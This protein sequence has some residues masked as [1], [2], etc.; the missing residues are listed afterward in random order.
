MSNPVSKVLVGTGVA[1]K[2]IN[3]LTEGQLCGF[4]Y[5]APG[6]I[7]SDSVRIGFAMGT[8][9]PGQPVL[10]AIIPAGSITDALRNN[11]QAPRNKEM[12]LTVTDV[13]EAGKSAVFKINYQDSLSIVPNQLK[14]TMVSIQA[15]DGETAASFATKIAAAFNIQEDNLFCT[16]TASSNVVT[17]AANTVSTQ[18]KYNRINRPES[19]IFTISVPGV[20][21]AV[22]T[23]S[24]ATT[25]SH[26]AGQ[27]DPAKVAYMED[28]AQGRRGYSDRRNVMDPKRFSPSVNPSSTYDVVVINATVQVHDFIGSTQGAPIGVVLAVDTNT[29]TGAGNFFEEMAEAVTLTSVPA[30]S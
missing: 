22:G 21:E 7:T 4:D 19:L 28:Q 9:T 18:S 5:D 15:V 12:E 30:S 3:T 14:N 2:D 16:V 13:P 24:T 29:V 23:Y 20:D 11:Y 27:G 10:S 6:P 1:Y 26:R 17:V 8:A 25:V